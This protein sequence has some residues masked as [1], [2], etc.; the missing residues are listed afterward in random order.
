[1]LDKNTISFMVEINDTLINLISKIDRVHNMKN[2][3]PIS[4]D[5][6]VVVFCMGHL[7]GY[8]YVTKNY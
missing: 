8:R 7:G 2:F 5:Q 6:I 4:K 1:M 3:I